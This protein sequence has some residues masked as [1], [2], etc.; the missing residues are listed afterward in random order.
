MKP[1]VL[2]SHW[3]NRASFDPHGH[4]NQVEAYHM[5]AID[6]HTGRALWVRLSLAGD[7][8]KRGG[9]VRAVFVDPRAKRTWMAVNRF[10]GDRIL[11]DAERPG[12]GIGESIIEDGMSDGIVRGDGFMLTWNLRVEP[13]M[14][15]YMPLPSQKL[16]H[17]PLLSTKWVSS[18]P[19]A[20]VSGVIEIW[21]SL[22]KEGQHTR[23]SRETEIKVDNWTGV[24]GHTWGTAYPDR[25][26]WAQCGGFDGITQP[27]AFEL[28]SA[29]MK[30]GGVFAVPTT[31]GRLVHG[32]ETFRFDTFRTLRS[33]QSSYG[34]QRWVFELDGPDGTLHGSVCARD[35][36]TYGMVLDNPNDKST[37]AAISPVADVDLVLRPRAGATR[38]M[39]S[40]AGVLEVGQY[41]DRG[42]TEILL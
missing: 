21:T 4:A 33:A 17:G 8:K 38:H 32:H 6:P 1:P 2:Q 15:A 30:L 27:T 36:I 31:F 7:A 9:T 19:L 11:V 22:H 23:D 28:Y 5:R 12:A 20:R 25:Y 16:Y 41:G 29:E 35:D 42:G 37:H 10:E 14:P 24:V 39:T 3:Y 18:I 40:N 13:Q 26:A 34:P